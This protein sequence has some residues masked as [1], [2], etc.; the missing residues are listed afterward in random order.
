MNN[1]QVVI[2]T[3]KEKREQLLAAQSKI[4][5]EYQLQINE[6]EDA[7]DV[8]VGK[9]VWRNSP[10]EVYDDANPDYIRNTEDGI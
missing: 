10:S 3:L 5:D 9:K 1:N 6:I 2:A 8:L 4:F 7:L